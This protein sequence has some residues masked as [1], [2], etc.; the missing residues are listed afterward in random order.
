VPGLVLCVCIPEKVLWLQMF[1]M[2]GFK[3]FDAVDGTA[4][5]IWS[6]FYTSHHIS[7]F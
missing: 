2:K 3:N 1:H 4:V 7:S 5:W 6:T